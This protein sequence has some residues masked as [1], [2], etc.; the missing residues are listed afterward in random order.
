[1]KSVADLRRTL[2]RIDGRGYKAYKDIEGSYDFDG[3]FLYI[4][5]VQ[6]DPFASPSKVRVRVPQ[7]VARLPER[8]FSNKVRRIALEDFLARRVHQA[9]RRTV[10]GPRGTGK[11]GLMSIDAGG[12]EV[13]ERTAVVVTSDWVEARLQVGLPASGRT[14]LGRQAETMLC[15]ELPSIV[16]QSLLWTSLPHQEARDFVDCIENQEHIR[17]KLQD[18]GLVA[19]V[20]D[21]AILPRESG[22]S[23]RPL[24]RDQAVLFVS[25]E[26]LRVTVRLTNPILRDG[27]EVETLTGM[28]VPKGVTLI[29]G[30]G[31]HGKSTLL[32]A[33]E[34]GVYPHIPGDGREY[35]VTCRDAVKIRAEDGRRVER[36]DISPFINNLPF[37]RST[38]EFSTDDA[39]G[40]TS[41][42]AN[43]MEALEVGAT[44]L[45]LDE[46]TSATNFM[47]R[48]ARMQ[49]LVRKEHEPITPFL[50]RV[51]ELYDRFGVS[52]VLVM[53][54]SGDYF[55][56]A[57]TVIMMREYV[58]VDVTL[59]AKEIARAHPTERR[60][61]ATTPMPTR[62][63]RVPRP[64]SLDASRGRREVKIEAKA[65]DL[66]LF[67]RQ[68][69]D[70]RAVEQL[71]DLSQTRAVGYALHRAAERFMDGRATLRQVVDRLE[72]FFDRE[73]LDN[74]APFRRNDEHPGNFAR[75]RKYEVAAAINR[76]RTVR[77][78]TG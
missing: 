42:A 55:D 32:R 50:D 53:G 77:V 68:T 11:S 22:V 78:W 67:G 58:P 18:L 28:G 59:Q 30:G 7:D 26:S 37:G 16:K 62:I 8:L 39:S 17:A 1:M 51:R 70:L 47:I 14:I 71:V 9:I 31:Y 24:A 44:L 66:L 72:E 33:L 25:P 4:D 63:E 34:R 52:T 13:L 40:S 21:G 19:F 15:K 76:L 27:G 10:R 74:L 23:D 41:Q 75:P 60:L 2:A 12:Q 6:G 5:H 69:I 54:G 36:V 48:D 57:D 43:I 56:V 73:G 20:A 3:F 49:A 61:E 46:D 35:V 64:E 38:A 29:V 45:L 65:T